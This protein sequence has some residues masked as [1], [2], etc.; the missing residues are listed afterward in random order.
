MARPVEKTRGAQAVCYLIGLQAPAKVIRITP[1][2]RKW[3]GNLTCTGQSVKKMKWCRS[4]SS[5]NVLR[6]QPVLHYE[7]MQGTRSV[8]SGLP[9]YESAAPVLVEVEKLK[10]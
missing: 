3:S 8:D 9:G 1:R 10:S 4:W 6:R 5:W 2:R 7:M